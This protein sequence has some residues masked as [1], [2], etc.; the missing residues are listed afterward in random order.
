VPRDSS[1]LPDFKFVA[2]HICD[3]IKR[4]L[5]EDGAGGG[6]Q[7]EFCIGLLSFWTVGE[8]LTMN[9]AG[10]DQRVYQMVMTKGDPLFNRRATL[11][12][13]WLAS[14]PVSGPGANRRTQA[15]DFIDGVTISAK[16]PR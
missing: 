3:S 16:R 11:L 1:G 7:G 4:H 5:R 15:P 14:V 12:L 10:A 2:T 8:T 6:I 9:S 13:A